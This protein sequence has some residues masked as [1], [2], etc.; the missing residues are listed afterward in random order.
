MY[1]ARA[2]WT[3]K[4]GKTYESIW[5]RESYREN[6]KVKTRNLINLKD[7][8]N[9]AINALQTALDASSKT[10]KNSVSEN[11]TTKP[12]MPEQ[13]SIAQGLSIGALFTVFQIAQ[14]LGI[15]QALGSNFHAKLALWQICARVLEQGSRLSAARM[16]KLH[17]AVSVLQ[18]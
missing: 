12:V 7:W 14:R 1:I 11:S 8:S 17:A 2:L 10:N 9:E 16:A 4:V 15:V 18:I 3:N 13:I 6:G 5:L